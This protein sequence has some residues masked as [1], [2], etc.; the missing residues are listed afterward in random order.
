MDKMELKKVLEEKGMDW[1]I[2]A[3][4]EGSIGYH[5]PPGARKL[6][7]RALA[8]ETRDYCERCLACFKGDLLQ[9]IECDIDGMK[10]IEEK[11]PKK[12]KRVMD[13]AKQIASLS[14]EQQMTVG[15]MYPTLGI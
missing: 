11:N 12:F 3:M 6:I 10:Y 13:A 7:E 2:A 9:M 5:S 8:G 15:L 14:P 4:V 1:L